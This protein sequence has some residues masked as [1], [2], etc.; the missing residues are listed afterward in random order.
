M[1]SGDD[2]MG[3]VGMAGIAEAAMMDDLMIGCFL[4]LVIGIIAVIGIV[5]RSKGAARTAA[6]L[7]IWLSY[8]GRPWNAFWPISSDDPDLTSLLRIFRYVGVFWALVVLVTIGAIVRAYSARPN[9]EL[10]A[11]AGSPGVSDGS[12]HA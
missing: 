4:F 12:E 8:V 5:Y 10:A 11:G 9:P 2:L 6:V 7:I 3:L 1:S